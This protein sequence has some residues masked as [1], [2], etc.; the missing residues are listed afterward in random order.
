MK[1][2]FE[3]TNA[4]GGAAFTV[5]VVTR[6]SSTEVAGMQDDGVLKIRLTAAPNEDA[7]QQLVQFLAETLGVSP[8]QIEIVAG[9]SARDKLISID[10]ISPDILE[11][12]LLSV[13]DHSGRDD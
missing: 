7:N 9:A 11:E 8:K 5:R 12:K 4:S 2:K 1:R 13:I 10:G 3:I 6:A